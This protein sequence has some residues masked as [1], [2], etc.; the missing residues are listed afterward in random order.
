[1][2]NYIVFVIRM[3]CARIVGVGLKVT[4]VG[5]ETARSRDN[6]VFAGGLGMSDARVQNIQLE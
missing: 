4:I 6:L 1:M 2:A 3:R 5:F